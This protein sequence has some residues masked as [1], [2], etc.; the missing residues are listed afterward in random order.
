MV[1]SPWICPLMSVCFFYCFVCLFLRRNCEICGRLISCGEKSRF[2]AEKNQITGHLNSPV[3]G[4]S[5]SNSIQYKKTVRHRS[6]LCRRI[7]SHQRHLGDIERAKALF[8]AMYVLIVECSVFFNPQPLLS[9]SI[10][11]ILS[12]A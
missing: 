6:V 9:N 5:P 11:F 4:Q 2:A 8:F 12:S 10:I 1:W 7:G 3:L